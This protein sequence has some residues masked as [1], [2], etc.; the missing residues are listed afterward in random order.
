MEYL[1]WT[2]TQLLRKRRHCYSIPFV[3]LVV[4]VD[5]ESA[6]LAAAS[7]FDLDALDPQP[8]VVGHVGARVPVR[9]PGAARA[10]DGGGGRGQEPSRRSR[11]EYE[12]RLHG[13]FQFRSMS[14]PPVAYA[15]LYARLKGSPLVW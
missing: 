7:R 8:E 3:F 1:D 5:C 2:Q 15:N 10:L 11:K 14:S 12:D 13:V 9:V 4:E 6:I